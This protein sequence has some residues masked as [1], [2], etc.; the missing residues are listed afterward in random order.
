MAC[1]PASGAPQD[2]LVACQGLSATEIRIITTSALVRF[3]RHVQLA[4]TK[5]SKPGH[6]WTSAKEGKGKKG[7]LRET[8]K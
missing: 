8:S 6:K 3:K 1:H 7:A 4:E 2:I 5:A